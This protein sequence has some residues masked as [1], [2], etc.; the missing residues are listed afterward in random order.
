MANG[1]GSLYVGASGLQTQQNALNVVANNLANVN[2]KG[3]VRQQVVFADRN[4][5]SFA[6]ASIITQRAGLGVD[7]GDV[8]HARDL[9]LDKAYRSATG[10]QAFY[11]ASYDAVSEVETYL[12]ETQGQAFQTSLADL[13][14]AFSEFA[15]DPSDAVNQNLVMQKASLFVS[16]VSS[17][18][19]GL[20]SYQSTI[21]RKIS[22]DVD[23]INE[24]GTKIQELNL[25]IQR[26]EAGKV[27]TAMDLRDQRDLYLDE[28]SSLA[29]V[30]Y[31]ENV[32]GI[33]KVQIDNVEFVTENNVYQM[34]MH[35]DKLT[36][37]QTPYWPQ[38]SDTENEDYYYVFDTDNANATN[39]TDVGEVKALLLARGSGHANYLDM[40]GLSAYDYSTGLS[41]SIM[42]NTEAELDTLFHSIV[43]AI[44]DTLC[45]NTTYGAV[46][47]NLGGGSITGVDATGKTWTITADT[48]ILDEANASVGSDGELPPHELF[49]RIGC[50]RYT[51]VS[52][53][54]GST[55]YVYNEEDP[56]D[57]STCYTIEDTVINPDIIDEKSL[58]PYKK[59]TGE[60]DYT[61]GANLERIWD[62]ENYLLNPTDTTPCTFTDF[63]IKW[64]GEVGTVGSVYSTTSDSLQGTADTIDNNRQM[65]VGVSSDEELTNM[66][67]YQ[68]AYNA[69]SRYINVVSTMIDYLL[70]SL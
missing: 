54:D 29:K 13:Y 67:R 65:V 36:G 48:K 40:A 3:Y 62:Q 34:A 15:K 6:S 44:N 2:T 51:K 52:L 31:S 7:I 28:L 14:E 10:R 9:F 5:T 25:Q 17:L 41:N 24:L 56:S 70:N 30:S 45:P 38:L 66:I 55:V 4:Y 42:M 64:I 59:Q 50:D 32:D 22:D 47:S 33:V 43:T 37:F 39:G 57:E 16:R 19:Q 26:V 58:I 49:S 11:A 68:S 12:Q 61:L 1:F 23:R 46:N 18:N 63:Y 27:E 21:N 60:I 20:Q 69:S 35:E 8:V 53:A